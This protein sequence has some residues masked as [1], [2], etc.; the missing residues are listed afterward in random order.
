MTKILWTVLFLLSADL[1]MAQVDSLARKS[2]YFGGGSYYI[3]DIQIQ[4]MSDFIDGVEKLE[5][6]E[7]VIFSHTDNIGSREY[8]EWLAKMRSDAV[9]QQLRLK[10]IPEDMM[11]VKDIGLE[12]PLYTNRTYQ[13]RRMNRRVD[14][15]LSPIVF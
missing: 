13:G 2:I 10:G 3:D 5:N 9:L 1:A 11:K 12:N 8:N 6:Y 7:I 15:I 4:E 14:V